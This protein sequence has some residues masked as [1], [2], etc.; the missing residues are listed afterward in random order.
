ML[1]NLPFLVCLHILASDIENRIVDL[2][3]QIFDRI[4]RYGYRIVFSFCFVR[5]F[6]CIRFLRA[7]FFRTFFRFRLLIFLFLFRLMLRPF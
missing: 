5:F 3:D 7:P 2:A 1:S 4:C 6:L